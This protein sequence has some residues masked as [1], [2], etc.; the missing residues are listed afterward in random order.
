VRREAGGERVPG[1]PPPGGDRES[2]LMDRVGLLEPDVSLDTSSPDATRTGSGA[3]GTIGV[4]RR[5][6]AGRAVARAR[7]PCVELSSCSRMWPQ[8]V[9]PAGSRC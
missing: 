7:L 3:S 4:V 5:A 8:A 1:R 9:T 6:A 2:L